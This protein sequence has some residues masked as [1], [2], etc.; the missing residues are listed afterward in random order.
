MRRMRPPRGGGS[1]RGLAAAQQL[2]AQD[3]SAVDWRTQAAMTST[4][5]SHAMTLMTKMTQH[6]YSFSVED[7]KGERNR[8]ENLRHRRHLRQLNLT[9]TG[10]GHRCNKI[11]TVGQLDDILLQESPPLSSRYLPDC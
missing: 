2:Q 6:S 3:R 10:L 4:L 9:T 11:R 8:V 1:G 7:I 5:C